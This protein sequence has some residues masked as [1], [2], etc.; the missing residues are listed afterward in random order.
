MHMLKAFF[1]ELK[2]LLND[3]RNRM[4]VESI[5]AELK[6]RRNGSLSCDDMFNYLLSEKELLKAIVSN[7]KYAFKKRVE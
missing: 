5:A 3:H 4:T 1:S 2:H 6:I 7:E